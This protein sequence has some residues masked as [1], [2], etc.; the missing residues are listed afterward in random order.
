MKPGQEVLYL[1]DVA[2]ILG[3]EY[4][5]VQSMHRRNKLPPAFK[6]GGKVAWLREKF[7]EWL[8]QE[9]TGDGDNQ[10]PKRKGRRRLGYEI[11]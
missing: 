11:E 8:S 4:P 2:E 7:Y 9:A 10:E 6:M 1:A 3:K 5:A